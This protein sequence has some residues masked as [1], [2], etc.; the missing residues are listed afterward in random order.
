MRLRYEW[1]NVKEK[2]EATQNEKSDCVSLALKIIGDKFS[3]EKV[4]NR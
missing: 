4:E 3:V 2:D 1:L